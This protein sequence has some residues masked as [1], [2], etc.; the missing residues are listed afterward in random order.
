[1]SLPTRDDAS[2]AASRAR[3]SAFWLTVIGFWLLMV[4]VGV[5]LTLAL[6]IWHIWLAF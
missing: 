1:M 5:T 3:G 4:V 2:H 6:G